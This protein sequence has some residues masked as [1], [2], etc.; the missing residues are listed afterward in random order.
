MEKGGLVKRIHYAYGGE[1]YISNLLPFMKVLEGFKNPRIQKML[2]NNFYGKLAM[3]DFQHRQILLDEVGFLL[4]S[5][6]NRISK[7]AR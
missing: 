4:Y 1:A 5:Q 6:A 3:K 2:A 7:W